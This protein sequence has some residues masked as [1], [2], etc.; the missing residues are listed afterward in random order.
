MP[1]GT[2]RSDSRTF[3]AVLRAHRHGRSSGCRQRYSRSAIREEQCRRR[4]IP[5]T[6]GNEKN[7]PVCGSSLEL[8]L[9]THDLV[10]TV[11]SECRLSKLYQLGNRNNRGC[12][13]C[14]WN[15]AKCH[16]NVS[17]EQ[18]KQGDRRGNMDHKPPMH[19]SQNTTL[20]FNLPTDF[21]AILQL[22]QQWME[23]GG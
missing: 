23:Q 3:D 12:S 5:S 8:A 17:H 10:E 20:Q 15:N 18:N 16:E 7:H 19:P 6:S 21:A 13:I 1:H 2:D 22:L 11:P 14:D 4:E 9:K